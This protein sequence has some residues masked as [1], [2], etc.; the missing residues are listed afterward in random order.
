MPVKSCPEGGEPHPMCLSCTYW[1][2]TCM[3]AKHSIKGEQSEEQE[4]YRERKL[5][6]FPRLRCMGLWNPHSSPWQYLHTASEASLLQH[7]RSNA[8]NLQ[9]SIRK[10]ADFRHCSVI[11]SEALLVHKIIDTLGKNVMCKS[12]SGEYVLIGPMVSWWMCV[13]PSVSGRR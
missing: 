9:C 11:V 10:K 8:C 7:S 2:L 12:Q 1:D 13:F 5:H 6:P 4:T 3:H